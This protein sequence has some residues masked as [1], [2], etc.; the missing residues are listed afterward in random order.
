[1]PNVTGHRHP[2]D[3]HEES[4]EYIDGIVVEESETALDAATG[5]VAL[6]VFWGSRTGHEYLFPVIQSKNR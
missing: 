5:L 4:H 1:M 3:A 6:L 2:T